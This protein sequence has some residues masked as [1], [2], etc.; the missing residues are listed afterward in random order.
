MKVREVKTACN[1]VLSE[2]FEYPVYDTDTYDGYTRPALF[3]ELLTRRYHKDSANKLTMAFT[4]K[5]TLLEN[6]HSE[7]LCLDVVDGVS[8]AFGSGIK[9]GKY[10]I[11]VDDIDYDWIDSNND[12]LQITIDFAEFTEI[13]VTYNDTPPMEEVDVR[14]VMKQTDAEEFDIHIE[15]V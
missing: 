13:Y 9:C 2:A 11:L 3:T 10:H 15:G 5:I 7:E 12:I 4:Y 14:V 1:K 8:D 6:E